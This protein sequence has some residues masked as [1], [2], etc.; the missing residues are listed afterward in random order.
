MG[1]RGDRTFRG[2]GFTTHARSV[3]DALRVERD[4]ESIGMAGLVDV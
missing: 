4:A 1:A 2:E 3:D